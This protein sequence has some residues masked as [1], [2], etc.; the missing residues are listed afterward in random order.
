MPCKQKK[1]DTFIESIKQEIESTDD[2]QTQIDQ[3]PLPQKR[4]RV[5]ENVY[6]SRTIAA[7]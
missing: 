3:M 1:V 2:I 5:D 6:L 7:K 4:S